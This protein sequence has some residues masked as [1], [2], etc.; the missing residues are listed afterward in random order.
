MKI[1][2]D[3]VTNSSSTSYIVCFHPNFKIDDRKLELIIYDHEIESEKA[4]K[5]LMTQIHLDI[6]ALKNGIP[7]RTYSYEFKESESHF[8]LDLVSK[9]MHILELIIDDY[10]IYEKESA[11]NEETTIYGIPYEKLKNAFVKLSINDGV[12]M[13]KQLTKG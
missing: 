5:M 4:V 9:R 1:K 12:D 13:L 7:V 8:D 3:F 11:V 6:Q 2:S 10:I